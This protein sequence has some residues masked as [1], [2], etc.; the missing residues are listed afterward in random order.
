MD[1]LKHNILAFYY[2]FSR[3]NNKATDIYENSLKNELQLKN[4]INILKL[5]GEI[6]QRGFIG[7]IGS[8]MHKEFYD[9]PFHEKFILTETGELAY[10]TES[11]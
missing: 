10:R 6:K 1:I 11:I 9:K 7:V 8:E 4:S 3:N 5:K 2:W